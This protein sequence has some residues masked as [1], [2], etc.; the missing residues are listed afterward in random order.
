VK[1]A[2]SL[3]QLI[4]Q[5]KL[6]ELHLQLESGADG[7]DGFIT[8]GNLLNAGDK[9]HQQK[10][11][12]PLYLM[13]LSCENESFSI[14]N[15]CWFRWDD[16]TPIIVG[17]YF[18]PNDKCVYEFERNVRISAS[19]SF[20]FIK[21]D[22]LSRHHAAWLIQGYIEAEKVILI[23]GAP[24]SFKSFLVIDM[25]LS[26][27]TGV[28][29]HGHKVNQGAVLYICGEG[30]SGISARI[31]AW[32]KHHNRSADNFY[33][34]SSP[35][36]ILSEESLDEIEAA[37]NKSSA[38][39]QDPKL[40][41]IDTLNRNFGDGDENS[42]S[43]MTRFIKGIDR[44]S[45][46]LK[47]AIIIVHHSGLG[48]TGRGRG[49]SALL[50]AMD[51]S[52]SCKVNGSPG[53]KLITLTSTKTKDHTPP[54]PRVFEPINIQIGNDCDGNPISSVALVE[55]SMPTKANNLSSAQ[56]IALKA[57]KTAIANGDSSEDA[58]K[59]EAYAQN[60]SS[61]GTPD[62]N[63]KTFSRAKKKLLDQGL[64]DAVGGEY[65]IVN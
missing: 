21:A 32:E 63:R 34:S 31:K 4:L 13:S 27:A 48:D 5:T 47:C 50:G 59:A 46:R 56:R 41:I 7:S 23:F 57:L 3:P 6:L 45:H 28:S 25:G 33:M 2:V 65:S 19:K 22:K 40:I 29:W 17:Q 18:S 9:Y 14:K 26:V 39:G 55:T 30:Q 16:S 54:D 62:A 10:F 64:I 36:K 51:F 24:A 49:S 1:E 15:S 43:D 11:H 52:Y 37:A 12:E 8:V 53:N 58:W 44:L 35:V 38:T 20:R 42:T 60:I 61:A